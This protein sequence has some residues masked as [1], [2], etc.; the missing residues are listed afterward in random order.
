MFNPDLELPGDGDEIVVRKGMTLDRKEF[1][2][3][4]DEYY[5]LRGWD[6]DA[7]LQKKKKLEELGLSFT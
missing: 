3:M 5:L 6:V 1:G 2:R 7:G 4:K